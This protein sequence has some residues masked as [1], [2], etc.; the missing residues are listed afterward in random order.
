M[1]LL[2]NSK[3]FERGKGLFLRF[4]MAIHLNTKVIASRLLPVDAT[5]NSV[6]VEDSQMHTPSTLTRDCWLTTLR[7]GMDKRVT[8][9][10]MLL[11]SGTN[12]AM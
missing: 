1:H 12:T 10:G 8:R 4:T 2:P 9:A 3:E 6:S 5:L 11:C 7:L